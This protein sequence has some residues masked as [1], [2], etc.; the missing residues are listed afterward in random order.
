MQKQVHVFFGKIFPAIIFSSLF[1]QIFA[2]LKFSYRS[3]SFI[4]PVI[5]YLAI[6]Q[7][8]QFIISIIARQKANINKTNLHIINSSVIITVLIVE[9]ILRLSG[10]CLSVYEKNGPY[11]S[12]YDSS[13][14]DFWINGHEKDYLLESKEFS[15]LRIANKE[16]FSDKEWNKSKPDSCF[17]IIG[18][19]DSFTEGMGAH[20]D[21]TWLKFLEYNIK[22]TGFEY[23][24]AG[25]FGSDLIFGYYNLENK[26]MKYSPNLVILCINLTESIDIMARDGLER[27]SK[28]GIVFKT[29]PWWECIYAASHLSRIFFNVFYTAEL[30]PKLAFDKHKKESIEIMQ[31]CIIK[32]QQLCD[33]SHCKFVCVFHPLKFE[34]QDNSK[35]FVNV[36]S[37]CKNNHVACIDL[38][39]YYQQP[40]VKNQIEQYYWVYDGHHNAYGYELM[41]KGIYEGLVE[42][43]IIPEKTKQ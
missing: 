39:S 7:L 19:G 33:S 41:A 30:I 10:V 37:F 5:F 8:I 3:F 42:Q 9:I 16:G 4:T 36:I 12:I 26:L 43:K 31:N 13:K 35:E 6:W 11:Y 21:S 32:Y 34:V 23:L 28:K 18:I 27:F 40:S 38:Y 1:I 2:Y 29:G 15:H 25:L 14:A 22:N 20:A 17:R 24:N